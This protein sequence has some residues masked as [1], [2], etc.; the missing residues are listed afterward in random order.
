MILPASLTTRTDLALKPPGDDYISL[1]KP[2]FVLIKIRSL[3]LGAFIFLYL[4]NSYM[5]FRYEPCMVFDIGANN[6]RREPHMAT[7]FQ[8]SIQSISQPW[9]LCIRC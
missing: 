4:L 3:H 8:T 5:Y 9:S 2:F 6:L 7:V 1:I